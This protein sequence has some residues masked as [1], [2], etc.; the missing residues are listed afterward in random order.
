MHRIRIKTDGM[1]AHRVLDLIGVM[2]LCL[3]TFWLLCLP[4]T[5]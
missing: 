2:S 3:A 4:V 5:L 1:I